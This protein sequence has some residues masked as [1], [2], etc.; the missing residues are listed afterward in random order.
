VQDKYDLLDLSHLTGEQHIQLRSLL[1]SHDLVFDDKPGESRTAQHVINV[2]EGFVPKA[3]YPY[4]IPDKLKAEVDKQ[5]NQLLLDGKIRKST[6]PYSH[7]IVCVSKPDGSIR[8]CCDFRSTNKVTINDMYPMSR[9]D[10]PIKQISGSTYITNLDCSSGYWQVKMN[11]R[12]IEKTAFVTHRGHF[13]WLVMPFGLKCAGD[14]LQD[15]I[16]YAK[17]YIDD[18]AV[19]D[20]NWHTHLKHLDNVLTAFENDG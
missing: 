14:I 10:D 17:A 2:T 8:V 5:I 11:P 9:A 7:P 3:S 1:R 18:V 16:S 4:R 13:E 20:S 15:H 6:S 19:H 12:D